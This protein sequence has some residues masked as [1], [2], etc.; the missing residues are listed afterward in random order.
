M[1]RRQQDCPKD[2]PSKPSTEARRLS[3][4]DRGLARWTCNEMSKLHPTTQLNLCYILHSS[5]HQTHWILVFRKIE[6]G[7]PYIKYMVN[8]TVVSGY[9]FPLNRSIESLIRQEL[10]VPLSP[11]GCLALADETHGNKNRQSHPIHPLDV[12][13]A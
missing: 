8:T 9:D 1:K 7:K 5:P 6:T 4:I 11:W 2:N 13:I 3:G 12:R 10:L